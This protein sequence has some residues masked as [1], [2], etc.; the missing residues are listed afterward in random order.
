M[1]TLVDPADL[2]S[3]IALIVED[4]ALTRRFLE[5]TAAA[6]YTP[7]GC[8]SFEEAVEALDAMT[9]RPAAMIVDVQLGSPH[10]DGLDFVEQ[11]ITRFGTHIPTLVLTGVTHAEVTGRALELRA[12]LL[13]KPQHAGVIRLFLERA[14]IRE[15][16]GVADIV[17][18]H[19]ATDRFATCNDLTRRQRALLYT[20]MQAAERGERD[21]INPNTRK[22]AVRRILARTGL[23]SFDDVRAAI[24][25]LARS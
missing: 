11:V 16:W 9:R 7:I 18:L 1:V 25:K 14:R 6:L 24:K 8:A 3:S 20:L 17:A 5:R 2:R 21:S 10:R 4:H 19:A 13:V 23:E 12:E 15:E 22:A